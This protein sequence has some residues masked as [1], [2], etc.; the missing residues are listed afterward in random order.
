MSHALD[1]I[2]Y[3]KYRLH[4]PY[5]SQLR[6]P[7]SPNPASFYP[8]SLPTPGPLLPS[9][10][11]QVHRPHVARGRTIAQSSITVRPYTVRS[12]DTLYSICRKRGFELSEVMALNHGLDAELIL[13][14][15]TILLPSGSVCAHLMVMWMYNTYVSY[16]V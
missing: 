10:T 2:Y 15:Q 1:C 4:N 7:L 8:L 3:Y 11:F 6:P 9:P 13:E 16:I 14:G 12:G 5:L